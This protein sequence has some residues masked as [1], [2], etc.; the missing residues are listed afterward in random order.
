MNTMN[1][2]VFNLT[3][4]PYPKVAVAT[5][6]TAMKVDQIIVS[7]MSLLMHSNKQQIAQLKSRQE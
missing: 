4:I 1:Y 7:E 6:A 5:V 3:R 2:F